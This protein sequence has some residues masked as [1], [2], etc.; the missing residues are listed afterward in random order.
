MRWLK[1]VMPGIFGVTIAYIAEEW[2]RD[3]VPH[4]MS[5][6]P[7]IGGLTGSQQRIGGLITGKRVWFPGARHDT[8]GLGYHRRPE[9]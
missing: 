4:V 3:R 2:P 8:S 5:I 9:P 1:D 7:D 6:L